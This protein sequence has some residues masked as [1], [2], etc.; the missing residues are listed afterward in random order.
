MHPSVN[1]FALHSQCFFASCQGNRPHFESRLT[2]PYKWDKMGTQAQMLNMIR[3]VFLQPDGN[4]SGKATMMKITLFLDALC[5]FI[6]SVKCSN[7]FVIF[8]I[9]WNPSVFYT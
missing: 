2:N 9:C 7:D 1:G 5:N 6:L 3:L 8:V 4:N